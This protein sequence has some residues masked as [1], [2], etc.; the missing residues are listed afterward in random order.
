[1]MAEIAG[2]VL[3]GFPIIINGLHAY[4]KGIETIK[5]WWQYRRTL[6]K[7]I[8]ELQMEQ[9]LFTNACTALLRECTSLANIEELLED[10]EGKL[11]QDEGLREALRDWLGRSFNVFL[12]AVM[13]LQDTLAQLKKILGLGT[14]DSVSGATS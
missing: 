14:G 10:P 9:T 5:K 11:W 2:L 13:D 6:Q 8:H 7:F 3:G 4:V 1:M 12:S